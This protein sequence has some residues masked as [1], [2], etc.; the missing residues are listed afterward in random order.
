MGFAEVFDIAVVTIP[1]RNTRSR[2]RPDLRPR[3]VAEHALFIF[4]CSQQRTHRL[5]GRMQPQQRV[6]QQRHAS[7][8]QSHD[9]P[10]EPKYQSTSRGSARSS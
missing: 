8:F 9:L 7:L 1:D 4:A 10:Y 6:S 2:R 5:R 3:Q